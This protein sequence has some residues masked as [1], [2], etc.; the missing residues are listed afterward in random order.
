MREKTKFLV[1][2]SLSHSPAIRRVEDGEVLNKIVTIH[3]S[4]EV[5]PKIAACMIRISLSS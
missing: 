3:I 1:I 2:F 4:F 5:Y